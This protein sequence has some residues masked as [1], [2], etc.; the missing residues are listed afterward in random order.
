[1][2]AGSSTGGGETAGDGI[3]PAFADL[4]DQLSL[5]VA[6]A[7][8]AGQ[9][10]LARIDAGL[11]AGLAFLDREPRWA[12][13][14]GAEAPLDGLLLSEGT[15]RLHKALSEVL[16]AGRGSVVVAC[17][18]DPS[19][20]LIAELLVMAALSVIRSHIRSGDGTP[21]MG[22]EPSLM[23]FVVE[24]YLA[25]GPAN[26]DLQAHGGMRVPSQAEVVPIRPHPSVMR[27][28]RLIACT[29]GLTSRE[30]EVAVSGND[31]CGRSISEPLKRLRQ[32]GLIEAVRHARNEPNVWMLTPYGR[33]VLELNTESSDRGP[34]RA[35]PNGRRL[36][37]TGQAAT[38]SRSRLA[39]ASGRQ[40]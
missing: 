37:A 20:W 17:E 38:G 5:I 23:R 32:R 8:P 4:L 10:W 3:P 35:Q 9:P 16:D 15:R 28:L 25:R 13:V 27:T 22:L 18:L 39:P 11:L 1:M 31:R 21:L 24:P 40:T 30:L 26:A 6:D 34:L 2:P 36:R 19:T 14:L 33:R 29:P 12:T 7:A